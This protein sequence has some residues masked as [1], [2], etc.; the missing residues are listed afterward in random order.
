VA[1]P[2]VG[3]LLASLTGKFLF[4]TLDGDNDDYA[5]NE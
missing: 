5:L 1:A 2:M 4:R 3:S